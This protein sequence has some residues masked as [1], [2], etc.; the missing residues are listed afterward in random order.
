ME[1][2]LSKKR[3]VET[4]FAKQEN[5]TEEDFISSLSEFKEMFNLNQE[6]IEGMWFVIGGSEISE[7]EVSLFPNYFNRTQDLKNKS[8]LTYWRC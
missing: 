2:Y 7:E 1:N 6:Q 3:G 4:K 8:C 5:L